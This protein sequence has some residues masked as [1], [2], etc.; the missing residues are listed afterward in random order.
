MWRWLVSLAALTYIV[1]VWWP[2][3]Q[4]WHSRRL[5]NRRVRAISAAPAVPPVP[6]TTPAEAVAGLRVIG[7]LVLLMLIAVAIAGT[8]MFIEWVCSLF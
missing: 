4:A 6:L 5:W 1:G 2:K 8:G 3:L 7:A